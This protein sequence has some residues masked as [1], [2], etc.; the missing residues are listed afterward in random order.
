VANTFLGKPYPDLKPT[1]PKAQRKTLPTWL[2]LGV[3][4]IG[5]ILAAQAIA[6]S[7]LPL[8][9]SEA[10]TQ[11]DSTTQTHIFAQVAVPATP[12]PTPKKGVNNF[13]NPCDNPAVFATTD[14][15]GHDNPDAFT[16]T[17][18]FPLV[19]KSI[20]SSDSVGCGPS[21][22]TLKILTIFLYKVLG[23]L[24]YAALVIATVFT[25]VAGLLYISGFANEANAKTAK[26][27]LTTTYV[28]LIIVLSARLI[29]GST[30]LIVGTLTNDNLTK[31][32]Q[33]NLGTDKNQ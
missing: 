23:L 20:T 33:S 28:G 11:V 14:S 13:I 27:V 9:A 18:I 24:N 26:K 6:S 16:A 1:G 29:L 15:S 32:I 3:S 22:W 21:Y 2:F 7:P 31:D 30:Q 17:R 10:T 12:A 4:G 25:I 19:P 5:L 8:V